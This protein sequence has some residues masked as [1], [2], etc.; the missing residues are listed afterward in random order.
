VLLVAGDGG[1]PVKR[2]HGAEL[3]RLPCVPTSRARAAVR[4]GGTDLPPFTRQWFW[5]LIWFG[6]LVLSLGLEVHKILKLGPIYLWSIDY[7][8]R[9]D[10]FD[11]FVLLTKFPYYDLYVKMCYREGHFVP[12][13]VLRK[14]PANNW[15]SSWLLN[16][17]LHIWKEDMIGSSTSLK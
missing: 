14:H 2:W 15:C 1:G 7:K 9:R 5:W 10:A 4:P 16:I 3:Q 8:F 13:F 17:L 12:N 11:R 6:L